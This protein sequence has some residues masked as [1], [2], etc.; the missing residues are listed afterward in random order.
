MLNM[1]FLNPLVLIV[2]VANDRG[3]RKSN[4]EAAS[5]TSM[6]ETKKRKGS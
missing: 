1:F 2:V 4:G 5:A 6:L 3:S